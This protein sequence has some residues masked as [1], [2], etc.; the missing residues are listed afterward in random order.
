MLH[1]RMAAIAAM[2]G[3]DLLYF[4]WFLGLGSS[5]HSSHCPDIVLKF[6]FIGLIVLLRKNMS[7]SDHGDPHDCAGPLQLV[8]RAEAAALSWHRFRRPQPADV[9]PRCRWN[10]RTQSRPPCPSSPTIRRW[11]VNPAPRPQ[12]ISPVRDAA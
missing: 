1:Q 8:K 10:R 6:Y 5:P 4:A 12:R 9:L 7:L 3:T 11:F 2:H